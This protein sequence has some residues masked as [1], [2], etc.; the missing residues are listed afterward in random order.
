MGTRMQYPITNRIGATVTPPRHRSAYPT[1]K[2]AA[3]SPHH[4][5]DR[6]AAAPVPFVPVI[7]GGV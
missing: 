4:S 6:D 1:A 7:D 5:V 2:A 3:A